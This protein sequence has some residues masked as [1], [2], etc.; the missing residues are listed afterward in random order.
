MADV[1]AIERG[2]TWRSRTPQKLLIRIRSKYPAGWRIEHAKGH[3][4]TII[5]EDVI[6][7]RFELVGAPDGR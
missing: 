7:A 1:V 2:Q 6:R 5:A 3:G 4:N